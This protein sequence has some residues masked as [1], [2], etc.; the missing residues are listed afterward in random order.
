VSAEAAV[1]I[2]DFVSGLKL[3][4]D[5]LVCDPEGILWLRKQW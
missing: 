2:Q 3:Q 5:A 4:R 1:E